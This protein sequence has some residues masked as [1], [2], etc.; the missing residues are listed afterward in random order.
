MALT[1]RQPDI[2]YQPDFEKYQRRIERLKP[3]RPPSSSLPAGFPSQ[4]TGELVWDGKDFTDEKDWTL[5]LTSTQ[6]EEI[7]HAVEHFKSR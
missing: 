4:L 5:S 2:T 6:L 1:Q 3:H 7:R